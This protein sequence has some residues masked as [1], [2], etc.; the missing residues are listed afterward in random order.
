MLTLLSRMG[1]RAGEVAALRLEDIDWRAGEITVRGKGNRRDRLPLPP[2]RARRLAALAAARPARHGAGPG[3]FI[4]VKAPHQR[5][6]LGRGHAGGRGGGPAGRA[7]H[8]YAHRL[9][10]SAATA[11]LAQGGSLAEIGQV[12]RHRRPMTT[13]D[14]CEGRTSRRCARWPVPGRERRHDRAA[15]GAGR[16]PGPAP[17]PGLQAANGTRSCSGSSR[18]AGSSTARTTVTTDGRGRL[19]DAAR[20]ARARAGWRCGCRRSAG[21]PPT[22]NL[23]PA[24]EVHPPDLLP[25]GTQRAV[26]YLY[27]D[28]DIAALMAPGGQLRTP[29]RARPSS[30]LIGLLAVTGLRIGEAIALDDGDFDP[31]QR[32]APGAAQPSSASTDCCRC[33]RP[34]AAAVR[35]TGSSATR[36]SRARPRPAL[37]VSSAG[38]RLLLRQRQRHVRQA[39]A[40]RRTAAALGRLPPP[41]A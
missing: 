32:H 31:E 18:L 20:R 23:D 25:G 30:T 13:A 9:R 21:S 37:L 40:P 8:V 22:C 28:E 10:H 12:L 39:G 38:T 26:P 41:A 33:T 11:M 34:R 27:S 19:G 6:D 15:P 1:L 35:T 24:A 16:L 2:T 29:L 36:C 17:R 14:L 4:R 3:V 7:G 5:P